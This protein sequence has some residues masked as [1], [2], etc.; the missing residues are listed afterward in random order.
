MNTDNLYYMREYTAV[1]K[2]CESIVKR[3]SEHY[4]VR[5]LDLGVTGIAT[6]ALILNL[7]PKKES[8]ALV[9]TVSMDWV[10]GV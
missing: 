3:C 9:S 2:L 10:E 5:G 1:L 8:L 7:R 6:G 4:D